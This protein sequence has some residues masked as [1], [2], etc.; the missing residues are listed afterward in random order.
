MFQIVLRGRE[1]KG[2]E[3]KRVMVQGDGVKGAAD[4]SGEC[5]GACRQGDGVKGAASRSGECAGA[6]RQGDGECG[7]RHHTVW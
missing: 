5:A 6:C 3:R 2:K 7:E 4:R 1:G